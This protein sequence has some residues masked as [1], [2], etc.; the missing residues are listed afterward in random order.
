MS[1]NQW[2]LGQL[3]NLLLM[4]LKAFAWNVR[5]LNNDLNQRQVIDLLRDGGFSFCALLETK[6]KKKKL[7]RICSKVLGRWEWISNSSSCDGGTGIVVGWDANVVRIMLHSQTSQLMNVFVEAIN[8]NQKF[9]CTFVY[10]HYKEIGRKLLWQDL[11]K[12][13]VAIKDAPWVLLGDFNVILEPSERSFGSSCVTAGME[14]FRSCISNIEVSD[15]VMSGLKFTWNKSP[16]SPNGLLKKLD[17]VMC[18]MGFL[19]RFPNSNAIFLPFVS[20]DH[21]PSVLDIPNIPGPK[22]KPFKFANFLSSKA[23]FLPA[24]KDVWEKEVS[25]YAMFSLVSKL[26]LLK[27]PL[28]KLKYAQGDLAEKVKTLKVKLCNLQEEM[29]RDPFNAALRVEESDIL[30]AYNSAVKD[31]ELFLKQRSKITWLSEGDFNTKYFHNAMKERR[32]KCR[33]EYVEDLEGNGYSGIGV[34]EQFVKYFESVLGRSE[35]VD[36]I[37]DPSS[38]F[39]NKLS[40]A[41]AEIMVKP[42][43]L[44]EIKGVL[45]SMEDDKAPGP[46]GFSS[47]FFKAAWSIVGADFSQ[48]ILDFFS[49][50]K[51]LKE[52]NA[53]VIALVPKSNTPKK[54][55]DFRPISCCN[56]VY[57]C[58]SKIIANRI[59]G[60]LNS[61]VDDCQSAFIPSRQ[62][63]DNILLSQELMRNYHRKC[64]PS[65]VAFKIDIQK[66]YDSVDWGFLGQCLVHFGFP[67]KMINWIMS[68]MTSPSFTICVNGDHCGYFKGMKGLRQ[69]DPLSPYLFTLIMEVLSLLIKQ[70]IQ[71]SSFFKFHW[72]CSKVNLTHICFADDL[73]IFSNGD[74]SSVS[75][76]KS[77]LEEFSRISGLK[78]S[79][80][81]S[82]VFFGNV[83]D[84][85]KSSIL[86]IMP[87][88]V[89][90]LPIKYLGVP[91]ISSRLCKQ[92]C[93]PLI[94]K[95]KLKLQNWKN[96]SLSFAG[97]LQL[98]KSVVSSIQVYWASVFLLPK[99]VAY[100]IEKLMRAFLWSQ[101]DSLRGKAK[102]KW[103]DVCR[104]KEQGGLGIKSIHLWNVALMTKHIWNIVSNKDSL[105]VKWVKSYRLVDR[106][107]VERNFWDIPILNDVS[108]SWKKILMYRDVIRNHIVISIGDGRSTSVW[109][110][111]WSFLGPL[112]QF[113]SKRDIFEAGLSLSCKIADVVS[114]GEWIWPECWRS[115]FLFLFHL[116]PPLI[117]RE[118]LDKALWKDRNDKVCSFSVKVVWSDLSDPLPSVPWYKIVWFSQNIPRHAF[119]L[120]L[121]INKRLNTQ[122]KIA[123]WNKVDVL[124]CPLCNTVKDDH[125]HLFFGCDFSLRVWNYFKDLMKLEIVPDNLFSVIEYIS[126]RLA[127]KSIWSI[128]QRLVIGATVYCLW[129]ERNNRLFQRSSRS[130]DDISNCIRDLVRLRLL[131]LKIKRSKQSLEAAKIWNFHVMHGNMGRDS[132]C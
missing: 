3:L 129:I 24:V 114:H 64:G 65:K 41:D 84:R 90:S 67:W 39:L 72:K 124:L 47:R 108:W 9:F 37:H 112:C 110:D 83:P 88:S 126:P 28:R 14:D 50:G 75:V 46:D 107:S 30:R 130:S 57:K 122:D 31:E 33:I 5:G 109:F 106:R 82:L 23:E 70:K 38:L 1:L 34:K 125:D 19:N 27:K 42:V 2:I 91:L 25:G 100:E 120:W 44:E 116:P 97:R 96:K 132:N 105:W 131:S 128:I 79:M 20:S 85:V 62:I 68:C 51:L 121:A 17:R 63:S 49:N 35:V 115:K 103:I 18:N 95:V 69:G 123:L 58:I 78:P 56:V 15:L 117:F 76:I 61:L 77:A 7:S 94:D 118:K 60:V 71:K 48:A 73:M 40:M 26:K 43:S 29:V 113:I 93:A 74:T 21:S 54:V 53:T 87:F 104:L 52:V 10:A 101:G 86:E 98:I 12:H 22:P 11:S 32:N 127:S 102:M 119:V 89:G 66:A 8:G 6:L 36:H 4:N 45:F 13:C 59:K 55:S 81:K 92:H 99:F 80:E 111:N 16:N